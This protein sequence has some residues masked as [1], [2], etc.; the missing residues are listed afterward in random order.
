MDHAVIIVSVKDSMA[1]LVMQF[2]GEMVSHHQLFLFDKPSLTS[3]TLCMP[4]QE[5]RYSPI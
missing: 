4:G 2:D 3:T 5:L 1:L